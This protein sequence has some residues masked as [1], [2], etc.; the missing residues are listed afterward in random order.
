MTFTTLSYYDVTIRSQPAP[1]SQWRQWRATTPYLRTPTG[2]SRHR[3]VSSRSPPS[4]S[5]SSS[6]WRLRAAR[7][8]R[9]LQR[10]QL[11]TEA[12]RRLPVP[13]SARKRNELSSTSAGIWR[14]CRGRPGCGK[15]GG[16]CCSR[17]GWA[18]TRHRWG[19]SKSVIFLKF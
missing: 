16:S 6:C 7:K 10:Q 13:W 4:T 3:P 11:F 19:P 18:F 9:R 12:W 2:A 15:R 1:T 5:R 17:A 14:S 8:L